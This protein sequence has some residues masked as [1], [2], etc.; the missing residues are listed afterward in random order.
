MDPITISVVTILGKYA[1]DKDVE[2]GKAVGPK[3]LDTVKEMFGMVLARVRQELRGEVIADEFEENPETYEKPLA[4][5]VE[6]AADDDADFARELQ[7][8]YE[9]FQAQVK[10]HTGQTGTTYSAQLEGSGA[11]AQGNN[12]MA[13]GEGSTV[14]RGHGNV[15]GDGSH[16]NVR[17]IGEEDA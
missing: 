7:A 12:A 11:I 2:L 13:G 3:A 6:A 15:V 9:R 8:L 14:I 16:S 4:K 17:T 10:A 1:L 5:K